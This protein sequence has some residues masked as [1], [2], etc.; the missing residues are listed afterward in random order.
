MARQHLNYFSNSHNGV[1]DS[2]AHLEVILYL[3]ARAI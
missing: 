1:V 3:A 2:L